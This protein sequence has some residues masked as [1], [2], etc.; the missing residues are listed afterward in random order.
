MTIKKADSGFNKGKFVKIVSLNDDSFFS[1]SAKKFVGTYSWD[2]LG[3]KGSRLEFLSTYFYYQF[4]PLLGREGIGVIRG[5][6]EV[7]RLG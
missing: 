5:P 1:Q 6:G 4:S 7:I 3:R 2:R